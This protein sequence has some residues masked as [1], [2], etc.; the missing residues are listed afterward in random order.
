MIDM[1]S[2]DQIE[3]KKEEDLLCYLATAIECEAEINRVND[4]QLEE[5]FKQYRQRR[6]HHN[7]KVEKS[8]KTQPRNEEA[9]KKDGEKFNSRHLEE[10]VELKAIV[11]YYIKKRTTSL[12]ATAKIDMRRPLGKWSSRSRKTRF[13]SHVNVLR[14]VFQK[15]HQ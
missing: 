12:R 11:A 1:L 3:R 6:P 13:A 7:N 10:K 8:R 5:H 4:V 2:L 14:I 9:E 15:S